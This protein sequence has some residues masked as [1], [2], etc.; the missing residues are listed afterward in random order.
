MISVSL[1]GVKSLSTSIIFFKHSHFAS[2]GSVQAPV[3]FRVQSNYDHPSLIRFC[4]LA[5]LS[6]YCLAGKTAA[7][8]APSSSTN[9]VISSGHA[10]L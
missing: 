10:K 8:G 6:T 5:S 4:F 1:T 2:W 7:T 3:I 9:L